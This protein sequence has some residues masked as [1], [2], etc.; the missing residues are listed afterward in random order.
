MGANFTA[1][2]GIYYS[3]LAVIFLTQLKFLLPGLGEHEVFMLG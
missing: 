1:L 2:N 3:F